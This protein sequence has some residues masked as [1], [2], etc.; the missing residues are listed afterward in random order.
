MFIS[1]ITIS[2]TTY[3]YGTI[4]TAQNNA[5]RHIPQSGSTPPNYHFQVSDDEN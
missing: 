1:S 4:K 3:H 5:H 2:E